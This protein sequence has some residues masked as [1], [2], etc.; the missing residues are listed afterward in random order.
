MD[1]LPASEET[2]NVLKIPHFA[3]HYNSETKEYA[4]VVKDSSLSISASYMDY[5]LASKSLRC[6][7]VDSP[8]DEAK[9]AVTKIL[10]SSRNQAQMI[11]RE[12]R[13]F[14]TRYD[15]EKH[16]LK[17]F[18]AHMMPNALKRTVV[19]VLNSRFISI[20]AI[21]NLDKLDSFWFLR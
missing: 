8:D 21:E 7:A 13:D 11:I 19:C 18:I 6:L 10:E 16:L 5:K 2:E 14:D 17:C 3:V 1:T 12:L 9:A 15:Q 4:P 20:Q